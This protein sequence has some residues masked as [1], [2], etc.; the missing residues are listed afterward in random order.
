MLNVACIKDFNQ[1]IVG[2]RDRN[3]APCW[4]RRSNCWLL[5]NATFQEIT[6][7]YFKSPWVVR[8][9]SCRNARTWQKHTISLSG[10]MR[11]G[12]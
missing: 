10:L 1:E 5:N 7:K 11:F 3:I 9:V 6:W 2:R 12:K 4:R 8:S